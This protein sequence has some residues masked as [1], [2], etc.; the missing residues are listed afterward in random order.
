[1]TFS[2]KQQKQSSQ[3]A[4]QLGGRCSR[5]LREALGFHQGRLQNDVHKLATQPP[6]QQHS[7][8][9]TPTIYCPKA[10]EITQPPW[11][12]AGSGGGR[13]SLPHL[14]YHRLPTFYQSLVFLSWYFCS[15]VCLSTSELSP[16]SGK[17]VSWKDKLQ[18]PALPFNCTTNPWTSESGFIICQRATWRCSLQ[19]GDGSHMQSCISIKS[20]SQT[21]PCP[22]GVRYWSEQKPATAWV[23]RA[24]LLGFENFILFFSISF[25]HSLAHSTNIHRPLDKY[26]NI[27]SLLPWALALLGDVPEHL[28]LIA[29]SLHLI[30]IT[31]GRLCSGFL[32]LRGFQVLSN[33]KSLFSP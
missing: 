1:M 21:H 19:G 11:G 15:T 16:A 29:T 18:T 12:G 27:L 6:A 7:P 28:R 20:S 14:L 24:F 8:V 5:R 26:R 25:V 17:G 32:L 23:G 4:N 10:G 3:V 13:D 33:Y 30:L 9:G 2:V 31:F 22:W